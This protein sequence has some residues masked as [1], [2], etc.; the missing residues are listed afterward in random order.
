MFPKVVLL[1]KTRKEEKKKMVIL[2]NTEKPY[3]G[4]RY[5]KTQ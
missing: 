2:S 1:E 3:I 5:N 4:I